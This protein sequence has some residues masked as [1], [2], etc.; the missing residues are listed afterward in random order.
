MPRSPLWYFRREK[1]KDINWR[2]FYFTKPVCTRYLETACHLQSHKPLYGCEQSASSQCCIVGYFADGLF[3][4]ILMDDARILRTI[5]SC[6][7]RKTQKRYFN[8]YTWSIFNIYIWFDF[9]VVN[10]CNVTFQNLSSLQRELCTCSL[11]KWCTITHQLVLCTVHHLQGEPRL[12]Q[13]DKYIT[14]LY[15]MHSQF[16]QLIWTICMVIGFEKKGSNHW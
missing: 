7:F 10:S 9:S 12:L 1:K 13:A 6:I 16:V 4:A 5:L 2:H 15:Q 3:I 14:V 11:T 8:Y